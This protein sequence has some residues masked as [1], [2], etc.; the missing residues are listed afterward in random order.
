MVA[1]LVEY[2]EFGFF[3]ENAAEYGL[4]YDEPPS[5][6]RE[7]VEV[8]G[9]RRISALVWGDSAPELVLV[10]GGSQNAHTWDTV[11]L[12]LG[13]PLVAI[14]L[15]GHG[16]SDGQAEHSSRRLDP[17]DLAIDVATTARRL[18]PAA[19]A[20]VGMSLGGLTTIALWGQA[21]EL[22]STMVLVD[23]LPGLK[24]QRAQHIVDF[25]NGPRRFGSLD[26]L[27]E[28]TASFNPT[29]SRSSLRRGILHNAEQQADGSWMW[30][31]ARHQ[32][33][34]PAGAQPPSRDERDEWLWQVMSSVTVPVLLA[35]GMR[36]DSVL[37][38]DDEAELHRRLPAA[39]VVHVENAGHS[40]QGD[41]PLELAA[42][43]KQF[44]FQ[45]QG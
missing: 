26:E 12:A 40:L 37:G 42:L 9:G 27:V 18:A 43:I 35:R 6:R 1:E 41:A 24:M 32:P 17:Q 8:S 20:V 14:D 3:H 5:V 22:I 30:R 7:F 13:R 2:D 29:R 38:D 23:V 45:A 28:R 4:A 39:Q 25:V 21:P 31:W 33:P 44:M 16:H 34:L 15:P 10:H 11:A 19:D 36:P